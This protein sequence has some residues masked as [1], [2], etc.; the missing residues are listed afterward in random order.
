[1]CFWQPKIKQLCARLE[2][3]IWLSEFSPINQTSQSHAHTNTRY[4]K[5]K[6]QPQNYRSFPLEWTKQQNQQQRCRSARRHGSRAWTYKGRAASTGTSRSCVI[7]K[8]L[9]R[10]SL[11]LLAG[12]V[13]LVSR[14]VLRE[15]LI[16]T[17]TAV[18]QCGFTALEVFLPLLNFS[19]LKIIVN[20][21]GFYRWIID[22]VAPR[23][24]TL[25]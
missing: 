21:A 25:D 10:T 24:C 5:K 17:M 19:S 18:N 6:R 23:A 16:L 1:M 11:L 22:R 3:N 7:F 8:S 13:T 9:S 14:A 4:W 2:K 12:A 15:R 20:F